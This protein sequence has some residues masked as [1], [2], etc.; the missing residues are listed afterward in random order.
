MAKIARLLSQSRWA[1]L[2]DTFSSQKA[3]N[4]DIAALYWCLLSANKHSPTS[5]C[6]R[7]LSWGLFCSSEH[8]L[9]GAPQTRKRCWKGKKHSPKM[10]KRRNKIRIRMVSWLLL[11]CHADVAGIYLGIWEFCPDQR[12]DASP[13][14]SLLSPWHSEGWGRTM[15]LR[16]DWTTQPDPPAKQNLKKRNNPNQA[17]ECWILEP[18]VATLTT[19]GSWVF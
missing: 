18:G 7:R 1:K 4:S 5:V 13:G 14:G 12:P 15:S 16:P 19:R 6:A 9:K 2:C 10:L 8:S 3:V 17:A 11:P